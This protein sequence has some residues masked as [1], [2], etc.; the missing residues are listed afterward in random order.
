VFERYAAEAEG[1]SASTMEAEEFLQFARDIRIVATAEPSKKLQKA[2]S[3]RSALRE[4]A[5][6]ACGGAPAGWA[7]ADVGGML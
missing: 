4:A 7:V 6:C 2:V 3:V 5:R 1:S